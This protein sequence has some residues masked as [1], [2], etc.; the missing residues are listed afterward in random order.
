MDVRNCGD[1]ASPVSTTWRGALE[2]VTAP[3]T[4]QQTDGHP[5]GSL[6]SFGKLSNTVATSNVAYVMTQMATA[7]IT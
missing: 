7:L 4:Q 2:R 6:H 5:P 1:V 3:E